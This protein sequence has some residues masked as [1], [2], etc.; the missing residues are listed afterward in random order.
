[1]AYFGSKGWFVQQLKQ[2][3]IHYH[4]IDKRKLEKYRASTLRQLYWKLTEEKS[5]QQ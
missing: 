5:P 3:G 4:P 1:M 2:Q